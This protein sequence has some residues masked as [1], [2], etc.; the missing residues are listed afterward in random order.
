MSSVA[1]ST[2]LLSWRR[3]ATPAHA[4]R[5]HGALSDG[6]SLYREALAMHRRLQGDEHGDVDRGLGDVLYESGDVSSASS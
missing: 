6:V 1:A 2:T 3:C 5:G 4:T